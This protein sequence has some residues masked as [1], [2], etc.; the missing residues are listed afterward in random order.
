M[1]VTHH[2]FPKWLVFFFPCIR[3]SS[4][5]SRDDKSDCMSVLSFTDEDSEQAEYIKIDYNSL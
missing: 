2:M 1:S 5:Y 4:C 3:R